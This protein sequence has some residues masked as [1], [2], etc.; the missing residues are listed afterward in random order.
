MVFNTK[1]LQDPFLRNFS[2]RASKAMPS[3]VFVCRQENAKAVRFL[4]AK[5]VMRSLAK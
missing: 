1:R 4:R 5:I 3:K 2:E